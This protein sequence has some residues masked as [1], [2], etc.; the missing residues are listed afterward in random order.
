M[1]KQVVQAGGRSA[2][3]GSGRRGSAGDAE[4]L[5]LAAAANDEDGSQ[6]D[7][8]DLLTSASEADAEPD[9]EA[10]ALAIDDEDAEAG[11]DDDPDAAVDV[12][13]EQIAGQCTGREMSIRRAIEERREARRLR[14]DLDYLDF[15][16]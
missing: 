8:D 4:D 11:D 13:L 2:R 5:E 14:D 15:D 12:D 1:A 7:D 16:D 9:T 10:A 3:A 6:I